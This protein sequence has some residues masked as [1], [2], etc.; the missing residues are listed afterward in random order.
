MAD[1]AQPTSLR[2]TAPVN[3]GETQKEWTELCIA[4]EDIACGAPVYVSDALTKFPIVKNAKS[5]TAAHG[6]VFGVAFQTVKSGAQLAI[7]V[8]GR[9]ACDDWSLTPGTLLYASTNAGRI[10]DAAGGTYNGIVGQVL[11]DGSI[12]VHRQIA[13][14]GPK[15]DTGAAG[16]AGNANATGTAAPTGGSNGDSYV[17]MPAEGGVAVPTLY[18]KAGG[19]W[20]ALGT[21]TAISS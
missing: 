11:T 10:S 6:A 19:A 16:A 21:L 4:G 14:Q 7:V 9:V 20:T 13:M 17:R 8:E 5:D 15:G 18:L 3:F 12:M 2:L 1:I